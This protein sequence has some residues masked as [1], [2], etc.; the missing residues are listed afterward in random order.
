MVVLLSFVDQSFLNI[1]GEKNTHT[2][3][4]EQKKKER[5]ENEYYLVSA[6]VLH[7]LLTGENTH[8]YI[9]KH[10]LF[11]IVGNKNV[12]R[13]REKRQHLTSVIEREG[14][15]FFCVIF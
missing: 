12:I 4:E 10:F 13:R 2:Q 5:E 6:C 3:R 1:D 9:N 11:Q 8:T 14:F 15:V 7:L